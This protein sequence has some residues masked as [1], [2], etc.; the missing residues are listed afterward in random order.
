MR[1]KKE[2]GNGGLQSIKGNLDIRIVL[3]Q[4]FVLTVICAV[5]TTVARQSRRVGSETHARSTKSVSKGSLNKPSNN[6]LHL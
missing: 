5:I 3:C 2:G 4:S 1:V 6:H